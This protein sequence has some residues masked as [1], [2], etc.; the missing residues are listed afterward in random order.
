MKRPDDW[1]HAEGREEDGR[2]VHQTSI[3]QPSNNDPDALREAFEAELK[4]K[5]AADL[6]AARL[7]TVERCLKIIEE[8]DIKYPVAGDYDEDA[9][10]NYPDREDYVNTGLK[11]LKE[12]IENE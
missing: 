2:E 8:A 5:F 3:K 7:E 6:K 11:K 10:Y 4:A 9:R 12:E 1:S